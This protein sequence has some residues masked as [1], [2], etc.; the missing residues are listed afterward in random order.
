MKKKQSKEYKASLPDDIKVLFGKFYVFSFILILFL[1]V[2]FPFLIMNRISLISRIF[3]L[4]V[5]FIFYVYV[6][7]D[8]SKKKK[9]FNSSI[10]ILLIT[11]VVMSFVTSI[12]KM[13]F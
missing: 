11:L 13:C 7:I 5:L 10:F 12:I 2:I 6:V 4:V 8:V 1:S 3:V 9:S